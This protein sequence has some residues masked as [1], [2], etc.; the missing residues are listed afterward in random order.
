MIAVTGASGGIGGRVARLL[1]ERGAPVRLI[2]RDA[3]RAPA[4]DGAEVAIASS[5][6]DRDAMERA[7]TGC[8]RALLVS[9]REQRDRVGAHRALVDAAAAAGVR[10]VAYTS[11]LGAAP[12]STFTFGRDHFHTEEHIRASGMAFTF[13]RDSIYADFIGLMAADGVIRGPAGDGRFSPVFRDDV[14]AVAAVV[15]A[16]PGHEGASYDLTGPEL[17]TVAEAAARVGARYEPETLDEARAA[18]AGMAEPW[19]VEGWVTTYA[20]IAN[21]ELDVLSDAVQRLTGQ[22]PRAL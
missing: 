6:E 18:R 3:A 4:L 5:Y 21:G 14:A 15:L 9:G 11:F 7:F 13:L 22:P 1:T 17:L 19:E 16:E 8:E 2:V 10:H 20:A 12:D